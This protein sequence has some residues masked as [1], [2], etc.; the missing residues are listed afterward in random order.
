MGTTPGVLLPDKQPN[1]RT[2]SRHEVLT[3]VVSLCHE[4]EE[5]GTKAGHKTVPSHLDDIILKV[6]PSHIRNHTDA[7]SR[8]YSHHRTTVT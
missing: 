2:F 4:Q 5:E 3:D 8:Q 6:L 1:P 7:T